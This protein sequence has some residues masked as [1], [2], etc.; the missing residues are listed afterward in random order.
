MKKQIM[1]LALAA[2]I[3]ACNVDVDS[4]ID[5]LVDAIDS[6]DCQNLEES[7]NCVADDSDDSDDTESDSEIDTS[8]G[9]ET[10]ETYS[11][12]G[13]DVPEFNDDSDSRFFV[14]TFQLKNSSSCDDDYI[15][16]GTG[17][18]APEIPT[19]V[20]VWSNVYANTLDF[21]LSNGK[22]G[23]FG[24][25]YQDQTIDFTIQYLNAFGQQSEFIDCTC[26]YTEGYYN[27]TSDMIDC[28]CQP[29]MS[30]GVCNI[31]YQ[32]I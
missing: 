18:S 29:S 14:G 25:M 9:I 28:L 6:E 20:R 27:Y 31:N 3:S 7:E 23:W 2:S 1:L 16:M 19:T 10:H 4:A 24:E 26:E 32:K 22:L 11:D 5:Q 21:E 13:D 30:D 8:G 12:T 15:Y 17:A